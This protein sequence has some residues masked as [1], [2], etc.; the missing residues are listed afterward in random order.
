MFLIITALYQPL[1]LL[2]NPIALFKKANN[3]KLSYLAAMPWSIVLLSSATSG[4]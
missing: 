4:K 2:N 1:F 3:Q